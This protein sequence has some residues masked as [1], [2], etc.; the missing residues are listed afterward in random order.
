MSADTLPMPLEALANAPGG[1]SEFAI[2]SPR[3]L[4]AILKQLADGSAILNFNASNGVSMRATLWTV[5]AARGRISFAADA[6][7]PRASSLTECEEATVVTYLDAVKIQF[8]VHSLVAVRGHGASTLSCPMPPVIY[9]IQRRGAY[10]VRPLLRSS[11]QARFRHPEIAEMELALRVLDVSIGG[12]ALFLP[13]DVPTVQ[14]G[15]QVNRV[16]I[17]LDAET[18]FVVD[19]RI[20]HVSSLNTES[21]GARLGCEFVRAGADVERLLQRFIDQTQKRRRMMAL[22]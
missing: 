18:R 10:R 20:L 14:P 7:D 22:D 1:L 11:P 13:E 21:K 3:E 12:T 16:S 8:D 6:A 17:D 19:L 15:V 4:A 2:T 5:D 9:R